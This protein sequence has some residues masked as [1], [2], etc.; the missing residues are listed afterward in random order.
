[1]VREKETK[2]NVRFASDVKFKKPMEASMMCMI[3][4]ETFFSFTKNMNGRFRCSYH[5]TNNEAGLYDMTNIN[6]LVQGRSGSMS[7]IKKD[8]DSL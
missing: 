2:K 5:I 1:M 3:D 8:Q 7:A 4:G 6:K